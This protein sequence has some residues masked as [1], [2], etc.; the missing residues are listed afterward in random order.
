LL[1]GLGYIVLVPSNIYYVPL[2]VGIGNRVNIVAAIGYALVVYAAAKLVGMLVFRE[3]LH[4]GQLIGTL[5]TLIA[6]VVGV[7]YT[8]RTNTDKIA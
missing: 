6:V 2:Q 5:A 8:R 7:D 3:L 4:S 1:I